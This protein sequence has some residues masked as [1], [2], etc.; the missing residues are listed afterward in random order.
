MS[1]SHAGSRRDADRE[2]CDRRQPVSLECCP[3]TESVPTF[4]TLT[5][6]RRCCCIN[7]AGRTGR[8]KVR[9][10]LTTPWCRLR[11]HRDIAVAFDD[12]CG[13]IAAYSCVYICAEG[14]LF[15]G[16]E[17][18]DTELECFRCRGDITPLQSKKRRR[19]FLGKKNYCSHCLVSVVFI[20]ILLHR[21]KQQV[22]AVCLSVCLVHYTTLQYI[23]FQAIMLLKNTYSD[24]PRKS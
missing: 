1:I 19:T 23:K 20:M 24:K 6:W 8:R 22:A 12:R 14:L 9:L 4:R 2:L 3:A 13:P 10:N 7:Q 18:S 5:C 15:H 17:C 16:H 11:L 21:R